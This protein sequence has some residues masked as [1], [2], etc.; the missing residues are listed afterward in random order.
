VKS[1]DL[2]LRVAALRRA[3]VNEALRE[4]ETFLNEL[5]T[6]AE[7]WDALLGEP[8]FAEDYADSEAQARDDLQVDRALLRAEL[9]SYVA[10]LHRRAQEFQRAQ[11]E[12]E[13]DDAE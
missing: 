9:G 11:E 12:E 1:A 13:S 4:D 3:A 8:V 10:E 6:K 7:I 5:E 2:T